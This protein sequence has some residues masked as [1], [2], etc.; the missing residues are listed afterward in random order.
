MA[1]ITA[2]RV[3]D[4]STTTSTSPFVVSGTAPTGYQ[5]FSAVMTT[6]DMCWYAAQHQTLAEWEV[7]LGTYSSANTLTR[8]TVIASSNAGSAVNFSAGTK[9]VFITLAASKTVQLNNSGNAGALGTITSATLTN[10]TGLPLT[11]GVTGTLP[12]ANGG[13]GAATLTANNVLLGNGTSALQV[14]A[15]GTNGN[16]LTS[17]GTIWTSATPSGGGAINV[18][19]FTSSGTWTKPSGYSASSRVL[20]QAWGGGASG[21]RSQGGGGGGGGYNERWITLSA[22]GAT[23]TVTIGAGGAGRT[24]N[25]A[26]NAGGNTTVGSLITAYGGGGGCTG[27]TSGGGGGGQLSAGTAGGSGAPYGGK[28][29]GLVAVTT[30]GCGNPSTQWLGPGG[31]GGYINGAGNGIN[32]TQNSGVEGFIHGG[33]GGGNNT[34]AAGGASVWAGGGGGCGPSTGSAGAG[35]ASSFGGNGGAGGTTASGTAGTQP[36][37]GGGGTNTGT[38]SGAGGDGQVIVTVFPA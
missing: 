23:E 38:T 33:G 1:F 19:S 8:T 15:P 27:G 25:A 17:N 31:G 12:V 20:I 29:Y 34:N 35:G 32:I 4:T 37:G 6:N 36:G 24:T 14:V 30:G 22:M 10:A 3:R 13:T 2:D 21:G 26:G 11:T 28:P 9:D 16:V 18:Q 5:T 7:G